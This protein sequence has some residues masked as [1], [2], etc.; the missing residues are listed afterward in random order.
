MTEDKN[1]KR[2]AVVLFFVVLMG[3]GFYFLVF[4]AEPRQFMEIEG[5]YNADKQLIAN[6]LQVSS[7]VGG[8]EGVKYVKFRI[9]VKNNDKIPISMY[10]SNLIPHGIDHARPNNL[11]EIGPGKLGMWTTGFIDIEPYNGI[12]YSVGVVLSMV[13]L[14]VIGV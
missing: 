14:I 4:K 6:G 1:N 7:V 11:I 10:V 12:V 3:I 13:V 8:F 5:L 9:N 2:W